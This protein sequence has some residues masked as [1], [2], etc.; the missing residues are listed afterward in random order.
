LTTGGLANVTAEHG[1]DLLEILDDRHR[2]GSTIV[3]SQ[4][5]VKHWHAILDPKESPDSARPQAS[6]KD[7]GAAGRGR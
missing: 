1:R 2:R 5:D 6:S 4:L 7:H 3:T